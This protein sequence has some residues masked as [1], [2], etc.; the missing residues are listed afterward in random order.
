MSSMND[1]NA[2]ADHEL[3]EIMEAIGYWNQKGKEKDPA[4]DE[5]N[6]GKDCL[7]ETP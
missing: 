4:R 7:G 5:S 3:I 6:S 1:R 2:Q